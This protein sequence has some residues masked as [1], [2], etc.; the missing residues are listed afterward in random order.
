MSIRIFVSLL[1]FF[2]L[3]AACGETT[4][5]EERVEPGR[6]VLLEPARS[7]RAEDQVR[8]LGEIEGEVQ[9]RVFAQLPE[10]IERVHVQ[11]GEQVREGA[12]LVTLNSG[13]QSAG[14]AQAGAAIDVARSTRD[15]LAAELVR[16]RRLVE[17]GALPR[18]QAETLEAQLRTAEA[19]IGQ[20]QA[21]QSS[22]RAQRARTVVRAP[23]SGTVA[24]LTVHTGDTAIPQ[25]PI[26]SIVQS[27]HVKVNLRVTEQDFVRV[28][29]GMEVTVSPPALP[30]AARTGIVSR[31][32]PVLD[33]LTRTGL[34][35]V[36]V[37][38]EDGLLR[39]GMIIDA[40]IV[41]ARRDG[42]TMAPARAVVMTP[43]T[44]TDRTALVFVGN[45]P[46]GQRDGVAE[47]RAVRLGQRY[48]QS[49][50]IESG[51]SPGEAL[52]V[53]GQHFLRDG[54]KIRI[55]AVI[56]AP[57]EANQHASTEEPIRETD[58]ASEPSGEETA[59][60]RAR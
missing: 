39:P 1:I 15:Q 29:P 17:A 6:V 56:A 14:L 33:P 24:L 4:A 35:E 5:P 38:N 21:G 52:V 50:E 32:S 12:P 3:L 60:E 25:I 42:V 9:V 31:V 43:E 44:D 58:S 59:A 57:G 40:H 54:A 51:V 11:E 2:H 34:V 37:D 49:I 27:R 36:R 53:E 22:A 19:Q 8:L 28:E 30:I 26:C 20:V 46:E 41:L 48:G 10:Q 47:R 7:G 23:V 55:P 13:L 45:I 16:A 18:V